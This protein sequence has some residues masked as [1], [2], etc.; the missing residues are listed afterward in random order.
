MKV[1]R[2]TKNV[3]VVTLGCSKNLVDSEVLMR[4]LESDGFRIMPDPTDE[5]VN[6]VIIN[7]CGFINDAKEESIET[8]LRYA[9]ARKSHKIENL[10]V[11]GC[12]SQRYKKELTDEIHEV[13]GFFGVAELPQ[14]LKAVGAEYKKELLGERH[15]TTPSHFAY[16]KISEGCDRTCSFCAIPL[17]RGKH[18]S[19]TIAAI[20]EEAEFLAS[21]G[22]KELLLIAQDL[23]YYGLDIYKKRSLSLLLQELVKIEGIDWIRLH[24][25]YP[26]AFPEDVL[27]IMASEPKI[28]KYLDIPLQHISDRIL[29]SMH[30]N[31]DAAKTRELITKIREQI[32]G[33]A[34]RTTMIVGYPGETESEFEELKKFIVEVKF[35]RLGVFTYSP[36]ENTTAFGL[37]DDIS[38]EIKQQRA[39]ELM[40][41]QEQI[42]MDLNQKRVGETLK[43]IIDRQEGGFW[44]GRS[45]FDSPE[46][47]NEILI[48]E[49]NQLV[50]G[51]FYTVKI[52]RAEAF[53]LFGEIYSS[54][55]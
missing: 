34:L 22:V 9:K 32:P 29:K 47:D 50:C 21:K 44:V 28:C 5:N 25:A 4:Q 6:I 31:H 14:I 11:M 49:I 41:I 26:A 52:T 24:Y 54:I 39:N 53:D 27:E 45:Q 12:L 1:K 46:V 48:P 23:T 33:I 38:D 55:G 7:T 51:D 35:D 10:F 3:Q 40:E 20:V 18:Q 15:L 13:D 17:I 43:V 36:E 30:R 42:S 2:I 16:L 37:P 19:K 8:I